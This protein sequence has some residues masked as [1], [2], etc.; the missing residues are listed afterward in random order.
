MANLDRLGWAA[1]LT[2][3]SHGARIGIRATDA[4]L[5]EQLPPHLPPSW[6]PAPSP[7]VDSLYSLVGGGSAT[8]TRAKRFNLLYN[9]AGRLAR[10][11]DLEELLAT[12]ESD[13]H[14]EVALA[15]RRRL[16]VH[17]GVVGW[18]GRAIVIPGRSRSGKSTLVAALVKAGATYFSDEY[19]VFDSRGRVYPYAI[20]LSLRATDDG[21]SRAIRA[22]S[23]GGPVATGSLPVGIVVVT[24][25]RPGSHWRPRPRTPARGMLAL[26]ANTVLARIRPAFALDTLRQVVTDSSILLGTR[27]EA[28]DMIDRLLQRA[29]A[30]PSFIVESTRRGGS[31]ATEGTQRPTS[32]PAGRAGARRVRP[33]PSP[34]SPPESDRRVG[35]AS[36]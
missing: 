7:I 27:G 23:L 12:L 15:A 34:S 3:T 28:E 21:P 18:G 24:E 16:F 2:F 11:L 33:V 22:D 35:V 9:G 19:A 36:L 8:R 14:F 1:G 6:K 30:R 29:A 17:A 4:A 25:Y 32:G 31:H 5:L 13:L 10:T 26:L 20:P